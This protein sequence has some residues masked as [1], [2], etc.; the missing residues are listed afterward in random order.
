MKI[1][2]PLSPALPDSGYYCGTLQVIDTSW[3]NHT[4]TLGSCLS[5]EG[6]I[7]LLSN[8]YLANLMPYNHS[9]ADLATC[10]AFYNGEPL[11]YSNESWL[12]WWKEQPAGSRSEC[13][14]TRVD[15][16]V[17]LFIFFILAI[18]AFVAVDFLPTAAR[19]PSAEI[20]PANFELFNQYVHLW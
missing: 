6:A 1:S 12:S 11:D 18:L 5:R 2:A 19:V 17:I 10:P 13:G 20:P 7:A 4:L 9:R 3:K 14:A 15:F 8:W 16:G